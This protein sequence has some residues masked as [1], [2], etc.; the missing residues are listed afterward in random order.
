M[1]EFVFSTFTGQVFVISQLIIVIVA[2]LLTAISIIAYKNTRVKKMI[3]LIIAFVL[4]AISHLLNY[5]DQSLV[6]IMPD[7]ARFAMFGVTT[8]VSMMMFFLAILK[9]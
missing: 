5:V 1:V 9:K 3:F 2:V 8:V 4:F 6:D 7:D